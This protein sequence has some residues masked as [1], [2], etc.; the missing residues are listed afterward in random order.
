MS[1][2][3]AA[4]KPTQISL[5]FGHGLLWL[6]GLV[7]LGLGARRLKRTME[8]REHA[9]AA[10]Q[11][12]NQKLEF[13]VREYGR[14]NREFSLI[15]EMSHQLQVC[16]STE[17]A[18]QVISQFTPQFFPDHA[19]ALFTL[20]ASLNLVE[21]RVSWGTSPPA[22]LVFAPPD[23]L[24][25]RRGR[26]NL[27]NHPHHGMLC[28]HIS[29]ASSGSY[30]CIP[31]MAQ[32]EALGILHL[33]GLTCPPAP[34]GDRC[35]PFPES[36]RRLAL[37]VAE[38]LALALANL[39][40]QETLRH[41]AIRDPLTGL[42]NRRFMEET[43]ERE[44]HRMLR[45]G[46]QLGVIMLDL[47]HFKRFNDTFGHAAG[48]SLLSALGI[49]VRNHI[50]KEDVACRYGGEEFTLIL[51]ETPLAITC[52]RAETLR[53][54]VHDLKLQHQGQSLGPI[55]VSLGVAAFPNHGDTPE[56]LLR[57]ADAALYRAKH[58]GRDRVVVAGDG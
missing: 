52:E 11:D 34:A 10:L 51:P 5:F 8:A 19:G 55:T 43:V 12:S 1:P 56:A 40:L 49:L 18:Y 6:L 24:A 14:H 3:W 15:N 57:A 7:G 2:L 38:H 42:F 54:L 50:R 30:L 32:G 37:T 28:P 44:V 48:D 16:A 20:N 29:P 45:K 25:L 27:V 53:R 39:K 4:A 46:A 21:S 33:Q 47:D 23:C 58:E 17:E 22:Q 31:M 13:M 35:E 26:L 36:T 9:E 41:Q